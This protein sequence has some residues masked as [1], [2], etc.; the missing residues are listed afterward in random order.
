MVK[1]F[2]SNENY[3]GK[4][5]NTQFIN[6]VALTDS[7]SVIDNA[8][9]TG[10]VVVENASCL[11]TIDTFAKQTLTSLA[12]DMGI[13]ANG[14]SKYELVILIGAFIERGKSL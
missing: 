12:S 14:K 8:K 11:N 4:M 6:G 3:N 10:A 2:L 13:N 9:R 5:G 1:I 7:Q